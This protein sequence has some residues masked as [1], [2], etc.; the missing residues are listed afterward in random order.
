ML[1]AVPFRRAILAF[2]ILAAVSAPLM[3]AVAAV[4][5]ERPSSPI[6]LDGRADEWSGA[7]RIVDAKTGSEAAFLNDG[8]D[9]YILLIVSG[10]EP[11]RSAE[12]SGMAV[13]ARPAGRRKPGRGAL[14]LTRDISADGYIVW[15]ERRG[16]FLTEADKT[17]I[18]KIPQHSVTLAFALDERGSSHG[19]LWKQ[20]GA[21]PPDYGVRRE[22]AAAVYEFRVPL[23]SAD[24]VPGGIGGTPGATVRMTL[25]WGRF[26]QK[27]LSTQTGREAPTAKSGDLSGAGLT[28]AQEFLDTFDAMS[29]PTLGA[30]R[31]SFS[32]D[33]TL[34]D[35]P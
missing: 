10:P 19:P 28:W 8:K 18:R 14:F 9:L 12:A 33:V 5:S 27:V 23:A 31:F 15:R 1:R 26:G 30:K 25:E 24:L 34:A 7:A 32:V 20:P 11:L 16:D 6:R 4:R 22:P 2:G 3:A 13:L 17:E 29:R 21:F 35:A